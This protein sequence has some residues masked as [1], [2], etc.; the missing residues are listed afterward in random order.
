MVLV[1]H[2]H[3]K[4]RAP[5]VR[6]FVDDGGCDRDAKFHLVAGHHAHLGMDDGRVQLAHF[7]QVIGLYV[8]RQ[9]VGKDRFANDFCEKAADCPVRAKYGENDVYENDD[10][11]QD[12]ADEGQR[13]SEQDDRQDGGG[14]G[15]GQ[16][17]IKGD[18]VGGDVVGDDSVDKDAP[19]NADGED[20]PNDGD[21]LG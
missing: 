17:H 4:A 18:A 8:Y 15:L 1:V 10:G 13:D 2:P 11:H 20:Q 21:R 14:D 5:V 3:V 12:G 19:G 7:S 16:Q 9:F 6:V